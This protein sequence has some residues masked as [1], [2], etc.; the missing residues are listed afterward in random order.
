[1]NSEKAYAEARA[2]VEEHGYDWNTFIGLVK[3]L[4]IMIEMEGDKIAKMPRKG[5]RLKY[6][7]PVLA[8][9]NGKV[10]GKYNSIS[11]AAKITGVC[12]YSIYRCIH[13]EIRHA[14]KHNG[15]RISWEVAE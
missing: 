11:E 12:G 8:I 3:A 5:K 13:G 15:N 14:G 10:V 1:M 6:K 4:H 9:A 2:M 7:R